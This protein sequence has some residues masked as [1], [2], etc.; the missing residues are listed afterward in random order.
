[1]QWGWVQGMHPLVSSHPCCTAPPIPST[2]EPISAIANAV[3]LTAIVGNVAALHGALESYPY[4]LNKP[5]MAV[6]NVTPLHG[7][8]LAGQLEC[9]QVLLQAG[10]D[11][12]AYD[13]RMW[14]PLHY[15]CESNSLAIVEALL[16]AGA[17]PNVASS[18]A[19]AEPGGVTPLMV[20]SARG[21]AGCVRALLDGGADTSATTETDG[22]TALYLAASGG[23]A[24]C[25]QDLLDVGGA[26][27]NTC[28]TNGI[29]ALTVAAAEGHTKVVRALLAAGAS[30]Q[31][32]A[33]LWMALYIAAAEGQL[34]ILQLL[35]QNGAEADA[36][37][38]LGQ[39]AAHG[40]ALAGQEACLAALIE[41]GCNIDAQADSQFPLHMAAEAG[42]E[43]RCNRRCTPAGAT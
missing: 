39:T 18:S 9:V 29:S 23:E 36:V 14:R 28:T 38:M 25:V 27:A 22:E 21:Y 43:V 1:M 2:A 3:H 4:Q 24:D 8:V 11:C 35:L 20:A 42:H 32:D 5:L 15:A 19:A 6:G 31:H 37:G 41:A 17:D 13:R 33:Q 12:D 10:A 30:P 26:D 34:E 16:A 7:A 40:A